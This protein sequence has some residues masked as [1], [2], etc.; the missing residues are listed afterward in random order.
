MTPLNASS[1]IPNA[2]A[3]C[4]ACPERIAQGSVEYRHD[5]LSADKPHFEYSAAKTS[6]ARHLYYDG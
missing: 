1:S 6:V 3:L 5:L 2:L 4:A